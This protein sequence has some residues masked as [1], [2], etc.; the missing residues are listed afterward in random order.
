M[1]QFVL[2]VEE[3]ENDSLKKICEPYDTKIVYRKQRSI[4]LLNPLV[5]VRYISTDLRKAAITNII[6]LVNY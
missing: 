5:K 6:K 2:E 1:R 4:K 3:D